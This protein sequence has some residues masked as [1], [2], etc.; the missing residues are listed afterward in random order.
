M[1]SI[2]NFFLKLFLFILNKCD[3]IFK[4]KSLQYV[5][6]DYF[7]LKEIKKRSKNK[8]NIFF[9]LGYFKIEKN[10]PEFV[11][12]INVHISKLKLKKKTNYIKLYEIDNFIESEVHSFCDGELKEIIKNLSNIY[13]SNIYLANIKIAENFH[14]E[15]HTQNYANF[16]HVDNNR[17][18]LFK[19]FIS[20]DDVSNSQ[21]PTHIIPFNK[22]KNFLKNTK[23]KDRYNYDHISNNFEIFKN[24]SLKGEAFVCN[25]SRCFHKAGVPDRN[26]S[27]KMMTLSFVAYPKDYEINNQFDYL[28]NPILSDKYQKNLINYLSKSTDFFTDYKLYKNYVEYM[29]KNF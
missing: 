29:R 12:K 1:N 15:E 19:I 10:F 18:T 24:I 5:V 28:K 20:L 17:L 26:N 27:R 25:T 8:L 23:Y 16:Y 21:G 9:K 7:Y 2:K 4:S 13:M 3:K 22:T 14:F 11:D 6:F